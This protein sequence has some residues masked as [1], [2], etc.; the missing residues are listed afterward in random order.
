MKKIEL[1][2]NNASSKGSLRFIGLNGELSD[3]SITLNPGR[4]FSV[5]VGGQGFENS[6]AKIGIDSPFFTVYRD[7]N[8]VHNYGD[9]V[10]VM[11]SEIRVDSNTPSG[12]Y[13]VY[14]EFQ[15]GDRYYIPGAISV[16]SFEN[17]WGSTN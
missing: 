16:E 4:T 13:N 14:I 10:L 8:L 5:Y 7:T 2:D 17:P 3:Q 11:S 12:L 6:K 15:N 9:S 1:P